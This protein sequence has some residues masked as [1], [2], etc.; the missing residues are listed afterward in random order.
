MKKNRIKTLSLAFLALA[1]LGIGV[2][3][4]ATDGDYSLYP[5]TIEVTVHGNAYIQAAVINNA[6]SPLALTVTSLYYPIGD[7]KTGPFMN[8]KALADASQFD[9]TPYLKISPKKL[10]IAGH[11]SRSIRFA[12]QL[13][14]NLPQGTYRANI[15]YMPEVK[16]AALTN[17]NLKPGQVMT[18]INVIMNQVGSIYA[19]VGNGN[20]QA[21]LVSCKVSSDDKVVTMSVTNNT[22]WV[23]NP[24][25]NVFAGNSNKPVATLEPVSVMPQTQAQRDITL[26]AKAQVD[27]ITWQLPSE[28]KP[29]VNTV[30]CQ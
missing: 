6:N 28:G 5:G 17:A 2:S 29:V 27:K 10:V 11:A 15:S 19:N 24:M 12:I 9:L 22:N 23:F 21:A 3:Y 8:D 13:P 16:S 1:G 14:N 30:M 20:A 7:G 26:P 25:V 18:G 4:A